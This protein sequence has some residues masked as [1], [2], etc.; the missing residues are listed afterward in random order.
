MFKIKFVHDIMNKDPAKRKK[1]KGIMVSRGYRCMD[2]CWCD[3][4][5][6]CKYNKEYT[7]HNLSVR[8]HNFFEYRLHIKLPHLIYI[9]IRNA[10]MSGTEMCPY[11]KSRL[12]T[13]HDCKWCTG[14]DY[15]EN[16]DY[17]KSPYEESKNFDDPDW[18]NVCRCKFFE[19]NEYADRYDKKTG[20]IKFE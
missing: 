15:C 20:E 1:I 8:V 2:S 4:A 12:Y 13:C 16:P 9:T 18:H 19:K 3:R 10:N 11:H 7:Y 5:S 17:S 6:K 14:K